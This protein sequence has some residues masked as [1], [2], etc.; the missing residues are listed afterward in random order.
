MPV[1]VSGYK[2]LKNWFILGN[3]SL[4]AFYR[5]RI[6]VY[7][8]VRMTP[9]WLRRY[10]HFKCVCCIRIAFQLLRVHESI[11]RRHVPS[12]QDC[13]RVARNLKARDAGRQLAVQRQIIESDRNRLSKSW[14]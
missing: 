14:A 1:R 11:G 10:P 8:P 5:I 12:L 7:V 9:N 13:N 3:F 4:E 6:Q 2:Q